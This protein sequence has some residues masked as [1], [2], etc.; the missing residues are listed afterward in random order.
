MEELNAEYWSNRYQ[1]NETGWDLGDLSPPLKA[2]FDQLSN[3]ELK[4]LIPGCGRGY[5]GIYL[6]KKGFLNVYFADFSPEVIDSIKKSIPEISNNQLICQDFFTIENKFDLI[7]EQTMFC[8]INPSLRERY[9]QKAEKLLRPNGKMVGL[10]FNRDFEGGPPFGG[11]KME[12][13]NLFSK[14]FNLQIMENSYN[15]VEPLKGHELF[16]IAN[17]K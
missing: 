10:L 12:Y 2:Y 17:K 1:N 6:F 5:E 7:I 9:V 4:I 3:K 14:Y 11:S 16:F 15:S 8:A 13:E